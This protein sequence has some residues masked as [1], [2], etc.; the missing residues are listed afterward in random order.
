MKQIR[1][2]Q[3]FL[4]R[5]AGY[6]STVIEVKMKDRVTGSYLQVALTDTV[7]R[8]PYMTD[9]LVEKNGK[10]YTHPDLNSM[11]VNKTKKYRPLGSMTTGYHLVDVTYTGH[12]I[13]VA[14][15]HGLCDGKGIKPFV[16]TLIYEYCR[17]KYRKKFSTEGLLLPGTPID[18]LETA[19]PFG[20]EFFAVESAEA[21]QFPE[22]F[23]LPESGGG[24]G[25]CYRTELLVDESAFVSAAKAV[26]A[27][28]AIFIAMVVSDALLELYPDADKA[29]CC[30]LAMDLRS[31]VGNEKT[32]RNCVSSAILPYSQE[33]RQRGKQEVAQE[34][35]SLLA[36]QR[37]PN[38]VKAGL[39]R[40]IGM[41][42]KLDEITDLEEKRR[43]L[44]FFDNMVNDTYVVSYLGQLR[45]ND[46]AK[47]VTSACFYGDVSCGLTINMLSASGTLALEVLQNFKGE[48]YAKAIAKVL[49]PYGLKCTS[50]TEQVI[51]G[52]DRS[53]RTASRQWERFYARIHR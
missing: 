11:T 19:E 15:H 5:N 32:H 45:L 3:S 25:I 10:Y 28:P 31:V 2:G 51:T 33:S 20:T 13:R 36:Q 18:P 47:Y 37:E 39:N 44:S 9:K 52:K 16:E 4:Y 43:M 24:H 23:S 6:D 22:K 42:N 8:F 7:K 40:Q 14:F 53:F 49:Q 12:F 50:E 30:N 21:P 29:M 34:Y 41:F 46:Y 26:K 17:Q 27:T 35:R 1:S 38:V 48:H